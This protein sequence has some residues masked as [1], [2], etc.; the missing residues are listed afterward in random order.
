MRRKGS[1]VRVHESMTCV[2]F[3]VGVEI[4]CTTTRDCVQ[5]TEDRSNGRRARYSTLTSQQDDQQ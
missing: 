1:D 3:A 2:V 4:V 5:P